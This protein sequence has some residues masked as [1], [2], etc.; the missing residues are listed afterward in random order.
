M[1]LNYVRRPRHE[2]LDPP[3]D[4][5]TASMGDGGQAEYAHEWMADAVLEFED[6]ILDAVEQRIR[7]IDFGLG[8]DVR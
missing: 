4:F 3:N 6:R 8:Q 5:I 1:G 2:L 7:K